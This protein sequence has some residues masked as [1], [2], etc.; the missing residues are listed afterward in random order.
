LLLGGP[1]LHVTRRG[2]HLFSKSLYL[3]FELLNISI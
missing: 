3:C 1:E 2:P